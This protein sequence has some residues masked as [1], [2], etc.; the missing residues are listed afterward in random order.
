VIGH[1][2]GLLVFE[3]LNQVVHVPDTL[4]T[5][6]II[7]AQAVMFVGADAGMSQLGLVC[8]HSGEPD[9]SLGSPHARWLSAPIE[10]LTG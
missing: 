2:P 10:W 4:A 7:A 5:G 9:M 8:R 3:A 6:L 1:I